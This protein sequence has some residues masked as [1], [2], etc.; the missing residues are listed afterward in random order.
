MS[1]ASRSVLTA[2]GSVLVLVL[3]GACDSRSDAPAGAPTVA[4]EATENAPEPAPSEPPKYNAVGLDICARTDLSPLDGLSLTLAERLPK[5]PT[6]G[7]GAA[8]LFEMRSRDGHPAS[9]LVEATTLASVGE[10]ERLY[11]TTQQV[12]SMTFDG[13][14]AGVADEAQAFIE[15][16]EPGFKY[17]EYMVRAR[18]ENLVVKVWLAVGGKEFTAKSDLAPRALAVLKSTLA[19]V[20]EA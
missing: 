14:L 17:S 7:P 15:E 13:E 18:S 16:S 12:S 20:P 11:Q 1:I 10:A 8:C 19:L 6:S 3:A 4:T 9:L 2:A 5:T